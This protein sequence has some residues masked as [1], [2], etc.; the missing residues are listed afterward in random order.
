MV[1][2][3]SKEFVDFVRSKVYREEQSEL[4]SNIITRELV[5]NDIRASGGTV[6]VTDYELS[7]TICDLFI[8]HSGLMGEWKV[9]GIAYPM[10]V[11]LSPCMLPFC[12]IGT[13]YCRREY[14]ILN[15]STD[16][17][18]DIKAAVTGIFRR[19]DIRQ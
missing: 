5:S 12:V 16:G 1:E 6:L 11:V 18:E 2:T 3:V 7:E 9:D 8:E 4:S 10:F 13:P 14:F 17:G 15:V 19:F